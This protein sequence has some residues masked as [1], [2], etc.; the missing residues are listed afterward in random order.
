MKALKLLEGV[1][2]QDQA[3]LVVAL[4]KLAASNPPELPLI[5]IATSSGTHYEGYILE[6]QEKSGGIGVLFCQPKSPLSGYGSENFDL[7]YLDLGGNFQLTI[8]DAHQYLDFLRLGKILRWSSDTPLS[9]FSLKRDLETI[10]ARFASE[11]QLELVIDEGLIFQGS[12]VQNNTLR[13][14]LAALVDHLTLVAHD[15]LGKEAVKDLHKII[16]MPTKG[17]SLTCTLAEQG[18]V[19]SF[20]PE[21]SMIA[22]KDFSSL[23]DE[24]F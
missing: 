21:S 13:D 5:R 12:Q 24:Q 3:L 20:D 19:I 1:E 16:F 10:R 15:P 7:S 23:I 17:S 14:Y 11:L 2:F 18:L 4:A 6:C 8:I 22:K 9:G